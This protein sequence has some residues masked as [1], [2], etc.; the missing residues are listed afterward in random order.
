MLNKEL[1]IVST[2]QGTEGLFE[3]TLTSWED[4]F[5]VTNTGVDL[6]NG[7]GNVKPLGKAIVKGTYNETFSIE[8][9]CFYYHATATTLGFDCIHEPNISD[10]TVFVHI[11][12]TDGSIETLEYYFDLNQQIYST[13]DPSAEQGKKL[14]AGTT[15]RV[16]IGPSPTP[17]HTY[18]D[19]FQQ[20]FKILEGCLDVE[21]RTI[22]GAFCR[23]NCKCD[24]IIFWGKEYR[25]TYTLYRQR[26]KRCQEIFF[27]RKKRNR[28]ILP[29]PKELRSIYRG[30]RLSRFKVQCG[31]S[32]R[33]NN[34]PRKLQKASYLYC[35]SRCKHNLLNLEE[36]SYA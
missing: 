27:R 3:L 2:S 13:Y 25:N 33:Y 32:P 10:T 26:R 6:T 34:C 24:S 14:Q 18:K 11:K 8:G 17:P 36:V 15:I 21:Q 35:L 1:W 31:T 12:H 16:Y 7:Y 9:L 5:R 30:G 23:R 22:I 4:K 20:L 19:V 28:N 29:V